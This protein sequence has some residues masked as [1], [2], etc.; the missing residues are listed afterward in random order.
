MTIFLTLLRISIYIYTYAKDDHY[1][2]DRIPTLLVTL[3]YSPNNT[4]RINIIYT[5][6]SWEDV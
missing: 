5:V 6:K 1:S 3:L 4:K 2:Y